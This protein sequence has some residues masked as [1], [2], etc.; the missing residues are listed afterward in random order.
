MGFVYDPTLRLDL[1]RN[2]P[3]I[4]FREMVPDHQ[5]V[6]GAGYQCATNTRDRRDPAPVISMTAT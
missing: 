5:L 6:D 1:Y 3:I 4:G 2:V